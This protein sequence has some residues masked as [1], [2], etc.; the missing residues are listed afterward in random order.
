MP[1]TD[2][3]APLDLDVHPRRAVEVTFDAPQVSSDGGW[4]LLRALEER[5]GLCAQLAELV[6]DKR[7]PTRVVHSRLEQVRQRVFQIGQL[8]GGECFAE[9]AHVCQSTRKGCTGLRFLHG[10]G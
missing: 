1:T 8:Q 2:R 10:A 5:L 6:P 4:L 3:L 7:A 9:A